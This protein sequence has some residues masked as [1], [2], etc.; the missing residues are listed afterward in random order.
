[1]NIERLQIEGGFL[2]GFDVAF[3]PGLNVFIGARGTGKTSVVELLRYAV[4]ARNYTPEAEKRSANHANAILADGS[5]TVTLGDIL[6]TVV[7]S[8]DAGAEEAT[9]SGVFEVPLILSQTEIETLGLSSA[10]RLQLLDSFISGREE[11]AEREASAVS[12]VR[13]AYNEIGA[14][15]SEVSGFREGLTRKPELLSQIMALEEQQAGYEA[16]S[17][18]V[19]NMQRELTTLASNSSRMALTDG[20]LERFAD[21]A[22]D[23]GEALEAVRIGRQ[24][25]ESWASHDPDPLHDFRSQYQAALHLIERASSTLF[26]LSNE[27]NTRRAPLRR[28]RIELDAKGRVLR[29]EVEKIAEGTGTVARQLAQ[30]RS[31]LA[32]L[33]TREKLAND[34]L[35]RLKALQDVRDA[36]LAELYRLRAARSKRREEAAAAIS[37]ALAPQIRIE[38]R[39]LAQIGGYVRAISDAL[40]GSGMKYTELA[41]L[42]AE[43]ISPSEL[44]GFVDALDF[45]AL[46]AASGLPL[47][48][49]ARLL[50]HLR[51]HGTAEIATANIDDDV[52]MLLLDGIDYKSIEEMSAGQRCTVVLSIVLQHGQ[53]T[54][55]IDQPE[56]HLDNA[57]IAST[58]VKALLNRQPGSQIILTT[59][60]P[61]IPVLG[62]ADLVIEMMSDGRHGFVE[63]C[64]PL[65]DPAAIGAISNVMEGGQQAFE[66]RAAFYREDRP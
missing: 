11:F 46:A 66:R 64:K 17:E 27:A 21:T 43:R 50:G 26:S 15:V 9:A 30:A 53:R 19:A 22:F 6:E 36:R 42:I 37:A 35:A 45:S 23:V 62:E 18:S 12:Q 60:N 39:A 25:L 48:R 29:A 24:E 13:I 4:G 49:A 52:E 38:V 7:V 40:R 58:V 54:V 20:T 59:H 63:V 34:R 65:Y 32:Q 5:V 8:R 61:N 1:M 31:Q 16:G 57:Y 33:E 44:L 28:S 55:V 41:T 56:D 10:G 47:D 3:S 14:L 51:D 2:D